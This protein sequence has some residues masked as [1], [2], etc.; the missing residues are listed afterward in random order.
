MTSRRA[1]RWSVAALIVLTVTTIA[2][3]A[4]QLRPF[5][6]IAWDKSGV[7][8][9]ELA[10]QDAID[11]PKINKKLIDGLVVTVQL[12]GYI[13][14]TAGGDP[15]AFTAHTCVVAYDLW[16]EVYK[17]SENGVI[18]SP[19]PNMKGVYRRC[20]NMDLPV[21]ARTD[22]P[23]KAPDYEL[24]VKVDVNPHSEELQKKI[25][26]WLTRPSGTTGSISPGDALFA[27]FANVFMSKKIPPA[28][29]E[30]EFHTG[31]FPP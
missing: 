7:L 6:K 10:M 24:H 4:V 14:P 28:D 3:A 8:H 9:G 21:V 15:V 31:A 26:Q 25:Q 23:G 27:T 17:V 1:V 16:N 30:F 18:K 20:T 12:R 11:D 2:R 29:L 13:I 22:L 5:K 19:A